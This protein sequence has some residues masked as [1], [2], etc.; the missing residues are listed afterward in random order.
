MLLGPY[1]D[2]YSYLRTASQPKSDCR[3]RSVFQSL[4]NDI[5]IVNKSK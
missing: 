5:D 3:I 4:Y 1:V 2:L